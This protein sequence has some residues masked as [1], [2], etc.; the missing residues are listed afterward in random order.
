MLT[1]AISA[2]AALAAGYVLGRIRPARRASDWAWCTIR[3]SAVTRN[4]WRWWATQPVFGVEIVLLLA[5]RPRAT[6]RAWRHR[7]DPPPPRS[8]AVSFPSP[9]DPP[10]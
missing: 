3:R 6:V 9:E 8:P 2:A 10:C 5:T 7:H 4:T 1:L